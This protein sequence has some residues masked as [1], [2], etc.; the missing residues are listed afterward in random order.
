MKRT[1]ERERERERESAE[2]KRDSRS[3]NGSS[4]SGT[5]GIKIFRIK[6]NI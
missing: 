5:N 3:P 1:R 2:M 6:L 4:A